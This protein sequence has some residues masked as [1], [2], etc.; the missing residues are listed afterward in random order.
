MMTRRDFLRTSAGG[1]VPAGLLPRVS[2]AVMRLPAGSVRWG[3]GLEPLVKVLEETP[4][5]KLIEEIASR[6]K[7]G[8]AYNE[9]L[10]A[11]FLAAVRNVQPRP[12]GF[13]FHAVLAI[14][15]AHQTSLSGPESDRWLPIFWSLDYFKESQAEEKKKTG[16]TLPPVDESKVP[17]ADKARQ[18]FVEAIEKWDVEGV[19][20]PAV[21]LART[22]NAKDVFELFYR[23]SMR[24][25]RDI[26]IGRAHV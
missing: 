26:E 8:L 1:A 4:R 12:V 16:W 5:E 20:G 11:L 23:H 9:V 17:A 21:A 10:A 13:K 2:L 19:D 14:N 6:V 15:A 7:K 3:T 24:D 22:G 25:F 18:A